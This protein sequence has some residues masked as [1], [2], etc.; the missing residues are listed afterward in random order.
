VSIPTERVTF[1]VTHKGDDPS[2]QQAGGFS[3]DTSF[4]GAQRF[5]QSIDAIDGKKSKRIQFLIQNLKEKLR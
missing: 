3:I 5:L 4:E 1:V 2:I